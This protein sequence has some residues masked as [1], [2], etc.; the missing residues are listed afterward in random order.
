MQENCGCLCLSASGSHNGTFLEDACLQPAAT[1]DQHA[2]CVWAQM[3]TRDEHTWYRRAD[4]TL[5]VDRGG[6]EIQYNCSEAEKHGGAKA[7]KQRGPTTT[8]NIAGT[9]PKKQ[10]VPTE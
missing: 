4:Q 3:R 7:E 10:S 6:H 5:I 8:K 1:A 9:K 2:P